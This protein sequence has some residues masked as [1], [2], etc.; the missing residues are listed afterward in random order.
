MLLEQLK[1][2]KHNIVDITKPRRLALLRVMQ[3]PGPIDGDI[4]SPLVQ[5]HRRPNRGPRIGLT[6]LVQPVE[7]RAVLA[8]VEPLQRP[9]VVVL[10]VG[11]HGSEEGDVVVGVEAA[12]VAVAGGV[13]AEEVEEAR[14]YEAVMVE[15]GVGHANPVGFHGVALAVVVVADVGV[16]EVADAALG[17]VGGGGGGEGG[18]IAGEVSGELHCRGGNFGGLGIF[19]G[20]WL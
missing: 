11:G 5:L 14:V 19:L 16:V 12:E 13:G 1:N 10:G 7:D 6:E 15:E 18:E 9:L 2:G 8:N 17:G 20:G 3:P 4:I